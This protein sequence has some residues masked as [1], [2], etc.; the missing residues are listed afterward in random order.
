[1]II[2]I[3][4]EIMDGENRVAAIPETV[5]KMVA[6]GC[7]VLVQTGAGVGAFYHDEDYI[8]AG[9][10]M[11]DDPQSVY[12]QADVILKVKEPLFNSDLQKHEVDMMH[13]GQVV[14]TFFHPA[15]PANHDMVKKLAAAGV[16]GLTLD[17]IPRISRAQA[18][19]ALSSMS[20]CA[21]YKG[22]LM[23][24]ESI[25]KF[26]PMIGSAVGM[27]KPAKVLIV[28]AGVAGLRA[29][30]TAKSLGAV[31]Y[32]ADIRPEACEQAKSLGETCGYRCAARN[33]CQPGRQ[34]RQQVAG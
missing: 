4:K 23:A 3:P 32:A 33:C 13:A 22:M 29:I 9:A 25:P 15:S 8:A 1:M 6:D 20:T 17:G 21:G 2:G 10:T 31:V 7:K 27:I 24:A 19:D 16:I 18:M 5:K 26:M 30:A 11:T 34:T 14:I 12:A 28:G